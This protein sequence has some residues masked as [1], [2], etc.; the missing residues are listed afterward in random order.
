MKKCSICGKFFDG[1]GNNAWPISDRICCDRCNLLVVLTKRIQ[2]LEEKEK[3][4]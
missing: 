1:W 2:L 3:K 4:S